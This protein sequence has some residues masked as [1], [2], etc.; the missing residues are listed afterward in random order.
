MKRLIIIII[1]IIIS[2]G[3]LI[4][5]PRQFTLVEEDKNFWNQIL[6]D[7]SVVNKNM[8]YAGYVA[9]KE[10]LNDL[11]IETFKEYI[12]VNASNGPVVT[13]ASYFMAKNYYSIGK[14]PEAAQ[15]FTNVS[16][17]TIIKYN[18]IKF[19]SMINAAI[20]YYKINDIQKFRESLQNVISSDME[21]KFKKIA[22]DILSQQ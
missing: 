16:K 11:S 4:S 8:L 10:N 18:E 1:F 2:A 7:N 20:S 17:S 5:Q 19:A 22:L 12:N 6:N 14:Y 21:G 13:L 9:Y 3:A 15:E